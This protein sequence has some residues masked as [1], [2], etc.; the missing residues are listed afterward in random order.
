MKDIGYYAGWLNEE[1]QTD[2]ENS[3]SEDLL[4]MIADIAMDIRSDVMG[5]TPHAVHQF[6]DGQSNPNKLALIRGL[7][8]RIELKL[9][10]VAK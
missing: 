7:C 4:E 10:E 2:I 3:D 6:F 8:D 5:E 9:M 1:I